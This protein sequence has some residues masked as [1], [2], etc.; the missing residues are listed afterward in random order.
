MHAKNNIRVQLIY[1]NIPSLI[2][3][4]VFLSTPDHDMCFKMLICIKSNFIL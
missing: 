3:L 4:K 2:V 1:S